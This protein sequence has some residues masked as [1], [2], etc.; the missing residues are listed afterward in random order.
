MT[1]IN[2]VIPTYVPDF[3]PYYRL[4]GDKVI[5]TI[6]DINGVMVNMELS[7]ARHAKMMH[8][9]VVICGEIVARATQQAT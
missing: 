8:E 4:M 1:S 3:N 5:L 2:D 6:P 9:G 7:I